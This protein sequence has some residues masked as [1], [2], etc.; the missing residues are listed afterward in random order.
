MSDLKNNDVIKT[1]VETLNDFLA[2]SPEAANSLF[3]YR[4]PVT[5][6]M[7]DHPHVRVQVIGDNKFKVGMIGILNG[8]VEPLTGKR[9]AS[10]HDDDDKVVGFVEYKATKTESKP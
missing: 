7:A 1:A 5:K 6:E 9:I 2:K 8:I 3:N 10:M 4:V